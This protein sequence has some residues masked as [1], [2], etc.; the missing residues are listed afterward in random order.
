[1]SERWKMNRI[2]FV[3]FWLYD[4]ED[5][6]FEDGKLLLRGQN[7]SGKSIT[8]QSF[9][10][11]VL[12]GDRTPSR[13]DPFGSSD[14]RMEYY[15]LGEEGKEESTGYLFL[16]FWKEDSG[17]YRTIGIGQKAKRGKPMDF[18]GFV[19]LD[20]RRVGYDLWLYKEVGSNKIPRDKREMKAELGED[21]FFTDSPSE[22][23]K[24][25]NQYIFGF[26]K[27]EQY[28]QFIKLLVKVRAPK[29]SKEFKPTKVY[30]ILNDSLQ[31]LTDE[32]LRPMVDAME[33]MDEIQD[34]LEMLNR[35]FDDVKIIRNE[36]TR[37]NQYM[38]AKKAQGYLGKKQEVEK[39]QAILADQEQRQSE[40]LEEQNRAVQDTERLTA[41]KKLKETERNA[42]LDPELEDA[43]RKLEKLKA[44]H[45][46]AVDGEQR[47]EKKIEDGRERIREEEIV[48]K[49]L[50]EQ[51]EL[52]RDT[53]KEKREN[54]EEQQEILQW[55]HHEKAKEKIGLEEYEERDEIAEHLQIWKNQLTTGRTALSQYELISG[56]YEEAASR[57]EETK[58]KKAA[59]EQRLEMAEEQVAD[60]IDAWITEV[61]HRAETSEE[62]HPERE[63]LL[64]AEQKARR[65]DTVADGV[66]IQGDFRAD[67]ERQRQQLTDAKNEKQYQR[68]IQEGILKDVREQ[69][70]KVQE[71]QEL[72]PERDE[73]DHNEEFLA[74]AMV[75]EKEYLDNVLKAVDPVVVLDEDQR[76]VVLTDEDYCLVIAGAGAGKTTTVAAKVKYLV[77]KKGIDPAQILVVS[78]TNKAVNEL[79]EK[80]QDD[81][82]V[83]CPIATFHSTGNAIIHKNSPEEKLNIVDN[84]KLYF[85]IRDY[86]RGSVMKNESVVNKLI[87][88]FATYF[89]APYEGDDLN[90]FFNNIAKANYSTMRSDLE[91]F[92]RE[93]IDTR[94][95]KSVTIQNEILRS[96][97]EVEIANFLYLNN[98]EY[99]YEPIYQYNIQYSH[100]PYTPDFVIYQNGKIAYIEHFGIT[101]NGKN[102]RYSQDELEQYKKA[103]NDKI[104]LHKQHDTTLIYTFSVYNDGKPLTE[105]LQEALEVKGFELKPRSNKEVMELLVAGE[106]NRY[107]RKL[108]NLI[109]RFISNFKVN[110][111]NA[112]EFNR[113][114]HSTQNVRSR[115]FLEICHDCYLEYDRW[116][117][118][119]KAVDF[120]DMINESARL[121]REV[122]E[123]KQK[124]SFKYIIVDEYQDISRQ[125]FD[126]TKALSEVT[127]AKIIAVGDDWQSIYAFSGSDITLFT[128]FSEKMGYA[129]MLKIVK[130]YRNSQEVID[131]AGNFIQKNSEQI[132]KRLLSPK[133]I[134]DPVIIYTYDST[135]KG[136]KGDRRS[137]SNYAV[138]HA[139]ETAL[140]QLI[141][142]K[143]QEGR[144]PGT[145]LLL[146]RYAFDGD[147][148]E[149]SGLFE[150]VRGGSKIKSVKYPK[151]DITFMTAH[152]SK[153]LGYDDVIIV[154]GKNETYGFPSK[155]EDDPVLA[156]VIKGDRSIDYAEERRLFYVAMTRTKNRVFFVAPEQN[157][158]EFLLELKKDYKNVVLHGNW[159]EEKPQS[160]AKKSC[161]LCG[162]PMQLKYKRAYGLRLYI[163]TNEPEI[164]GFMTND[165][166]AGKLCIQ[167]CDKCRDGYLVV[168]SSKENGY[169]LGCTNYKTNGTGCN[170]SIGMKYYYDQMGY[171]MEIVTESPVAISR[172]EKENPVKRV[173]VT[174]VSTDD[175]VEIEKTTAASVRYKRWILNNVVDTVLRALQDVS[176]VRYYGVTMLTD[177]LRGAN[178]KRIL[179]NGLEM[180][181]E[182]G[183][184]KEIPR[185]TIQNIIEWLINEHY[186]LKTKEKYPVLHSTY[187]GLHYSESLTKTK[188]EELKAYL[189]KDEA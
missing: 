169:F 11:F 144:Q 94:T 127:D 146:G 64:Q 82:G 188:L 104:K 187:E 166:R 15:F 97:Q 71:Q 90:G 143:K 70:K 98:I 32:E 8:T 134:T 157:P 122:K 126:L 69:L 46:E 156:F 4:E 28:E 91:D 141:M 120:E 107:V 52:R 34:S 35:A 21:N 55:E 149:K 12:D 6:E 87:M 19:I 80:I 63:V 39:E 72:E 174:Q 14:R 108:I 60:R 130:T 5:F 112:E 189:E 47:W 158:S 137:G 77:D 185:E 95:K 22:Y 171:R 160:I 118:E 40:A 164:C 16:E 75:E 162:Y 78:F 147:H 128:K 119:N 165:Y 161:P 140:T 1:M 152:S 20:G 138:A 2:G 109:C 86:F 53:L 163:C 182:Y 113:M 173:A 123:M 114:Y 102:D 74:R 59:E 83:P 133:N 106:E 13:L 30:D 92:K 132:R 26:R 103:I 66:E 115:L 177:I 17:E 7:G 186:I 62:W 10:P 9:I 148:L 110:G 49:K 67:Y 48:L 154:N 43:D 155:I 54:L 84:S 139:V 125:R 105:H 33:K 176:K 61:F 129:K 42:L 85:V 27:E 172:I 100:K 44:E 121:L 184:L 51:L 111:Y 181:P 131:I 101:E 56:Q 36:Y 151:L 96:H 175:Y 183:M 29:L 136:R 81:L 88:F 153:G 93:V 76:K 180:V 73:T 79:K 168:K 150:F 37:Y 31:T 179:D 159:N 68:E 45:Q 65:Y 116:L 135:A 41:E 167:K 38:L 3:N 170:K 23:K 18:W 142:Y 25:V 24:H 145:I 178:S 57:L 117:K 58:K 124:L 89:D 50:E 99:E